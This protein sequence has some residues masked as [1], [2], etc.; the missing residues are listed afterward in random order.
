VSLQTLDLRGFEKLFEG[1]A[2]AGFEVAGPRIRD[3]AVV[4]DRVSRPEEL[5]LGW[6]DRQEA[7][8][9]RLVQDP[10]AGFF[11]HVVGPQSWK[12]FLSPPVERLWAGRRVDGTFDF[13]EGGGKSFTPPRYA[14]IGV[15]ACD[16]QAVSVLDRVLLGGKY[17]D[18]Y[19]AAARRN[20]FVVA[21]N[22]G[23]AADTCFCASLG[24]GPTVRFGFD[25]LLTEVIGN[26]RHFFIVEGGSPPGM[27]LLKTLP[28]RQ[29]MPEEIQAAEDGVE[30]AAASMKRSMAVAGVRELLQSNLEHPRWEQVARRCLACG[31]CTL[32]CP[33]CFCTTVE[34]GTDITGDRAERVRRWDSCF[35]LDFSYIHGGSV[36]TSIK[37]RYRHWMTHKLANWQDQFE[38]IGCVGCG[39]CITW[40]PVGIDITEELRALQD[41]GI[42]GHNEAMQGREYVGAAED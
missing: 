3:G 38:C 14:F 13:Q 20:V 26:K 7:G 33:T 28:R 25:L 9:Y 34:D 23:R 6:I 12:K 29:A 30:A 24:T 36:R 32:V 31:N 8:S 10:G 15:R 19:Y 1:L 2:R 16:I 5:P 27:A 42:T 35:N 11:S 17:P 41:N 21:V 40:C 4:Y 18:P 39:R 22:C 37:A